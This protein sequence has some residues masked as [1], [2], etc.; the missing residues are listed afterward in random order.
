MITSGPDIFD[1][2]YRVIAITNEFYN[3]H[4]IGHFNCDHNMWLTTLTVITLNG[5]DC[6]FV[7]QNEWVSTICALYS[8]NKVAE[9]AVASFRSLNSLMFDVV[10]VVVTENKTFH[11][12]EKKI[13]TLY[14]YFIFRNFLA[15]TK[16]K[17]SRQCYSDK[18]NSP[19]DFKI[20]S[21]SL[22]ILDFWR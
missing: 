1:Y 6:I 8:T 5:F 11:S 12:E 16:W 13:S 7:F 14:F 18:P 3:L 20:F 17:L 10:V 4:K 21:F 15:F 19:P 2:M 9:A 22:T